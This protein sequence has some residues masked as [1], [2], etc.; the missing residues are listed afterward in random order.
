MD[1]AVG[2]RIVD[3]ESVATN[4]FTVDAV[5]S[6]MTAFDFAAFSRIPKSGPEVIDNNV[7]VEVASPVSVAALADADGAKA[8]AAGTT[9]ATA[10]PVASGR[11]RRVDVRI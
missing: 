6:E 5:P 2:L 4:A 11:I 1:A 7:A 9:R 8:I 10:A 3:A